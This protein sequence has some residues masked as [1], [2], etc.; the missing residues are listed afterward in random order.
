MD[1]FTHFSIVRRERRGIRPEEIKN[2][3]ILK[4][5]EFSLGDLTIICGRNN[6]GKTYA[7]YALFG[8]LDTWR[9]LLTK[10]R[11][12]LKEKIE[13]LLSD[14]VISLDLQEYVQQCESILTT[15]CQRYVRQ[16]P[17][18][19]AANEERFKNV[20]EIDT[21]L[22]IL[23]IWKSKFVIRNDGFEFDTLACPE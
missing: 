16:I 9:R 12:G 19:F 15:G 22:E 3:G 23:Y 13:Q 10:P 2:L 14:G 11:F 8:F 4:Q 5:A 7:T 18:V 20:D 17:E 21:V 1:V 6:T